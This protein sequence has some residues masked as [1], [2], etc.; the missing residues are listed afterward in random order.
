MRAG[1]GQPQVQFEVRG[2]WKWPSAA[3]LLDFRESDGPVLR[4]T[5]SVCTCASLISQEDSKF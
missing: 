2:T 1:A 3:E 5:T 4:Y